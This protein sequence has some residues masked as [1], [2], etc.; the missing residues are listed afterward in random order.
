VRGA[1]PYVEEPFTSHDARRTHIPGT[2]E[3]LHAQS[4]KAVLKQ[5]GNLVE[6]GGAARR[7]S[8]RQSLGGLLEFVHAAVELSVYQ[9]HRDLAAEVKRHP[10]RRKE[11]DRDRDHRD[12]QVGHDQP[13]AQMPDQATEQNA[14]APH[15]HDAGERYRHQTQDEPAQQAAS[16]PS[17]HRQRGDH[18]QGEFDPEPLPHAGAGLHP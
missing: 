12:E 9:V 5:R 7:G 18:R 8:L 6:H 1:R 17:P 2:F 16:R 14:S 13:V 11:D 4:G 15:E 3:Q 10:A